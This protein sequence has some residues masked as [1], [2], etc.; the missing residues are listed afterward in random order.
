MLKSE[1][2][3]FELWRPYLKKRRGQEQKP[4]FVYDNETTSL[5]KSSKNMK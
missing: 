2:A 3:T 1:I 4:I 5:Q